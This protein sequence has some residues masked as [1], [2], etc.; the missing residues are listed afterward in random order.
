MWVVQNGSCPIT[1]TL[2]LLAEAVGMIHNHDSCSVSNT[3]LMPGAM[4]SV[5]FMDC[6]L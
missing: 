4:V 5:S 3:S 1:A 2:R 6:G